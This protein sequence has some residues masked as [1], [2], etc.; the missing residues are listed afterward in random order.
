MP[1]ALGEGR[2]KKNG[3]ATPLAGIIWNYLFVIGWDP[4]NSFHP[5]RGEIPLW[6][7][8]DQSHINSLFSFVTFSFCYYIHPLNS[9]LST[10]QWVLAVILFN[11]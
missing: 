10:V 8:S 3:T 4:I 11:A 1:G 9:N 6:R 2:K 5:Q 7:F